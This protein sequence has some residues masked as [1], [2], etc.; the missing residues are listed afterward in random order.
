MGWVLAVVVER[1]EG[2]WGSVDLRGPSTALR[3]AQ[4]DA[5]GEGKVL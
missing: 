4:D 5:F 1:S 3:F 2:L